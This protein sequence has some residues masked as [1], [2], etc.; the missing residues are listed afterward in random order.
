MA[1]QIQRVIS[2]GLLSLILGLSGCD[3]LISGGSDET[4]CNAAIARV[5]SRWEARYYRDRVQAGA[6]NLRT[7]RFASS[8]LTTQNGT[9]PANAGSPAAQVGVWL[10]PPPPPP[11]AAEMEARRQFEETFE[12]PELN[13]QTQYRLQCDGGELIVN[14]NLYQLAAVDFRQGKTVRVAYLGDRVL[15]AYTTAGEVLI[16]DAA[17]PLA[18]PVAEPSPANSGLP[19]PAP[20]ALS[21][22]YVDPQRG[23]DQ[24]QGTAAQPLRT[25]TQAIAQVRPG[26][27]IQLRPG[28]Y[29]VRSGERFPLQLPDR[30]RLVGDAA[31]QGKEIQ[32]TGGGQFLSSTWAGQN[33]TLVA[34]RDVQIAGLTLTNPNTRGTA[35]WVEQGSPI[36]ERNQLLGS[37]REGV[38]VSGS[39]TPQILENLVEQNGGNGLAFTRESGGVVRGNVIRNQGFGLAIGDRAK[40]SIASNQ[41]TQNQDGVVI[42]GAA[43]PILQ[44][45]QIKANGRDG[46]VVTNNAKPVLIGNTFAANG[47]Y[48]LHNAT[49]QSLQMQDTNLAGLK[50]QGVQ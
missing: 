6:N 44:A 31:G 50:L 7:E 49:G 11:P 18:P 12:A 4:H 32:V 9:Q 24:Q 47:D 5:T 13:H 42:N 23:N 21:T 41:I 38:F 10:P 45:N 17:T 20:T 39:A 28:I 2:G 19:A 34:N 43:Q 16:T 40:P 35:I 33:V 26:M 25:I 48:D 46:I 8:Q 37:D 30:V 14:A 22:L 1:R 15:K 27:T 29:S 3:T 36:I